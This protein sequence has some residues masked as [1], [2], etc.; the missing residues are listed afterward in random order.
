MGPR[1]SEVGGSMNHAP[2]C[3]FS[4]SYGDEPCDCPGPSDESEAAPND[5]AK[6]HLA[7]AREALKRPTDTTRRPA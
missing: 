1:G 5:V 7:L 3:A 2:E 6:R 4:V